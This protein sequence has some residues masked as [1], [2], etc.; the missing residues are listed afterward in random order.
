MLNKKIKRFISA[1]TVAFLLLCNISFSAPPTA[2]AATQIEAESFTTQSGIRTEACAEGGE[3]IGYIENGDY[4]VYSGIDF[5]SGKTSFTARVASAT[6]GGNIELRLDSIT[7]TLIGT[8][9]VTGTG[10]FQNW[11]DVS[12]N[13]TGATGKHDLYLKF[14][15]GSGYLFNINWFSFDGASSSKTLGDINADGSIDAIDLMLIKKHLLGAEAI[16]NTAS[17]DLDASGAID[18]IDFALM[19]QYL[20]GIITTFPGANVEPEQPEDPEEP[21][22]N[23]PWDW[24]GVIGT[25]QSLSVGHFGT[26][27]VSTTQPY[28]NL[29]L[30]LGNLNLTVPPY[31]SNNSQLK[32]VP[33]VEPI[34]NVGS[35]WHVAY[36]INIWGETPHTA[37]AN[38]ITALVKAA[39]GKDYITAHTVVG[40]TGQGYDQIKKGAAVQSDLGHSYQAA[41]FEVQAINRLAKAAGKTYGVGGITLVH[42]ENDFNN[43]SY[44]SCIRQLWSDYNKDIKAITGQTQNIPLFLVQQ[45]S[46]MSTGTA[47]STLAQWKA[48]VDYPNDIVCIGP[49]YQRT[50]GSDHVHLTANAYQQMG[51]KFGQVYYERVVLGNNWQPL[52]PTGATKSG[53]V[54]TVNFHVPVGPLVWDTT[55]GAP[56]QSSNTEWKNGK[57]FEVTAN[58]SK[59]T[60]SSVEI[61]GD[62][63]KITCANNLPASG[64]KVGYAFTGGSTRSNGTYRWGLLRDSDPFKGKSG[65]AQPNFCVAFEMGV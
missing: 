17:A 57:G 3:N 28:N 33:L 24:A 23:I 38:Q 59:V 51:E 21:Q 62:S 8:C 56:N 46:Y 29:K 43:Q 64:V 54:I 35:G 61:S 27:V 44:E 20:L 48:G 41:L 65:V 55:L 25:G 60:I 14:T 6:S 22:F 13:L 1:M 45:H 36:P 39:G 5:G 19:K 32:M 11:V 7:G 52:Q 42:G 10:D 18:A 63:V 40:E 58:G 15:G 12:C 47:V 9:S 37:M 16:E 31:D 53:N 34:R 4:A 49:N 26:P 2:Y 50:Y 30:S